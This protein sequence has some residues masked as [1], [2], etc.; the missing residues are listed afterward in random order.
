MRGEVLLAHRLTPRSGFDLAAIGEL[1]AL[2]VELGGS[3]AEALCLPDAGVVRELEK[4][5][6]A[7][8]NFLFGLYGAW[9][10]GVLSI[11]A[12]WARDW[13]PAL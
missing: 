3:L 4:R 6:L 8:G 11:I 5:M 9:L 13:P 10:F 7:Q 2:A 1:E 12:S